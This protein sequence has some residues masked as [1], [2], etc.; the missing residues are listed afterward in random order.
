M[1]EFVAKRERFAREDDWSAV[2]PIQHKPV[3]EEIPEPIHSEFEEANLCFAIGAYKAC[4]SMYMTVLE[5]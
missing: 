5:S 1:K 2:Y 4:V 3:A